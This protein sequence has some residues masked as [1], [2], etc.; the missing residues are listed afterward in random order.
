MGALT[1]WQILVVIGTVFVVAGVLCSLPRA[2]RIE[3]DE[4]GEGLD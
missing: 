4:H 2:D 3:D 1:G